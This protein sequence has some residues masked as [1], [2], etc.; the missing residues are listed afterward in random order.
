MKRSAIQ[1]LI[2]GCLAFWASSMTGESTNVG[3][4]EALTR[5]LSGDKRFV[6]GKSNEPTGPALIERRH[7]LA[8]EQKPFAV[9]VGCSDS[10]VPPELV[11]DASLG[12]IFVIRT[13]GEVVDKVGLGS[14]E[15]AIGHLG[16]RLV[17]VLGHQHCGAVSA[18]VAGATDTGDI[19]DVLRAIS[20]AVEE[21]KG[22]PGDPIENAVRANA[23]NIAKQLQSGSPIIAP[24]VK[25]GEVK[26]VA[27]YYS[28]DTGQVELL[29]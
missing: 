4:D 27:A 13:A 21:T 26:I 15:Y 3:A 20:P 11:F 8:K 29:K 18:A 14:I 7:A 23:R 22:Q 28:L 6:A 9:V 25:S 24:L 12:D 1:M 17:V 16:T 10:R 2:C 5:L 19:P